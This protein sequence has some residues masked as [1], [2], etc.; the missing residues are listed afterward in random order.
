[1]A[2][3]SRIC[4]CCGERMAERGIVLSRNPNVCASC[5][6]M[7]DGMDESS[8]IEYPHLAQGRRT[9]PETAAESIGQPEA[10]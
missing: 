9:T 4:M 6:S 5:S 2:M 1:M 10:L 7:A 8:A 3:N